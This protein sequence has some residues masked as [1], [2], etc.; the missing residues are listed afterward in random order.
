MAALPRLSVHESG[1]HLQTADGKPFFWQGDTAW[2]LFH[3]LNEEEATHY[4][5]LRQ[6]QGFNLIQVVALAELNG[7]RTPNANGDL[8]LIDE[9]PLRPNEAYFAYVDHIID[10]AAERGIYVGLLPTWGDKVAA[11]LWG[12]GPVIFNPDNAFAY[13]KWLGSRYAD[14]T[15]VIWING[16]DRPPVADN[17][18]DRAVWRAMAAG[19]LE[20]TDGQA[21]ISYH[22]SGGHSSA[23]FFHQEEWLHINMFQSG[24]GLGRDYDTWRMIEDAWNQTPA[25]PVLD[26]EPNYEGHPVNAWPE[27]HWQNGFFREHD[28][29]KQAWRSVLAGGCG[30]TYGHNSVWQM[31]GV[32]RKGANHP[33]RYW[34]EALQENAAWQIIHLRR[35]IEQ[36]SFFDRIP[37]QTLVTEPGKKSEHVRACRNQDATWAIVYVPS[38]R[39]VTIDLSRLTGTTFRV[40]IIDPK[41]G[42]GYLQ[43]L[44]ITATRLIMPP[45][46]FGPD[47]VIRLETR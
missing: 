17:F 32:G 20:G 42:D 3:R 2:E 12:D 7:L 44:P 39:P 40:T 11:A 33:E 15:S 46:S 30:I 38:P 5:D 26:G 13:A 34:T 45:P 10:L 22:P 8:P 24:H 18:D 28:V 16:G 35:L 21:L 43:G 41:T 37:D 25:K 6:Q 14:R 19:L 4:L 9:D 31:Y 47:Y 1:R 23:E 36:T 27:W 29:R